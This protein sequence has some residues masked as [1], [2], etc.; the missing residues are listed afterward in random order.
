MSPEE[1]IP[2]ITFLAF[3]CDHYE[4]LQPLQNV[5]S[6]LLRVREIFCKSEYSLYPEKNFI[7]IYDGKA[8]DLRKAIQDYVFSRSAEQDILFLFFAGHGTAVGRDDFGFCMRDAVLHPEDRIVLP[9]SVV[10]LSEIIGSL[11]IKNVSLILFVDACYSGQISKQ[12]V[13]SFPEIT[14]EMSRSLVANTG[15]FF[16]LVSSCSSFEQIGDIGVLSKALKDICDQGTDD[17]KA[18]LNFSILPETL[19]ERIDNHS[20]GDTRSRIFIPPGR[21]SNLPLCRNV[22]YFEPPEP[23]NTYSFTKPYLQLLTVLWNGGKP[24]ALNPSEIL[25]KTGSQ[26]AYA[27]HNKLSFAPWGLLSTNRNGKRMLTQNGI[28]FINGKRKIPKIIIENKNTR[29]CLP[30]KGSLSLLVIDEK[31]LFGEVEKVFREVDPIN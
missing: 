21:I 6:D 17:N 11:N 23:V 1:S 25:D 29:E 26:S 12:L 3:G 14:V 15:S 2:L 9:T 30:A 13:I 8:L 24:I 20:K 7:E 18:Y 22:Q 31:N 16:G 10:K 5:K 28:E 27:N 19:T 4:N